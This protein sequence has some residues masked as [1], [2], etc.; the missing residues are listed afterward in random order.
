MS[1]ASSKACLLV[2]LG[3]SSLGLLFPTSV[4]LASQLPAR[5]CSP[6]LKSLTGTSFLSQLLFATVLCLC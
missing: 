2:P 4:A 6:R 3:D 5:K 1:T